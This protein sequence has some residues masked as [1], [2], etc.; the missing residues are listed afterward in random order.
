M[1]KISLLG[2]HND[3]PINYLWIAGVGCSAGVDYRHDTDTDDEELYCDFSELELL[4]R[5]WHLEGTV[6]ADGTWCWDGEGDV[7]DE[8]GNTIYN[9]KARRN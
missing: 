7:Y 1:R 5:L 4:D 2:W 9:V 8:R 6:D 3:Q